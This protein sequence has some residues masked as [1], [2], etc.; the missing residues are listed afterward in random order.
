MNI[1]FS[2]ANY[3]QRDNVLQN[4]MQNTLTVYV[5]KHVI[6]EVQLHPACDVEYTMHGAIHI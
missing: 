1:I 3:A 6:E 5:W 4:N 2:C